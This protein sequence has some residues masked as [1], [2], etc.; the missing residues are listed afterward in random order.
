MQGGTPLKPLMRV[1][2]PQKS[3]YPLSIIRDSTM[4]VITFY[5]ITYYTTILPY[6]SSRTFLGSFWGIMTRDEPYPLRQWAWIHRSVGQDLADIVHGKCNDSFMSLHTS[7]MV[8]KIQTEPP[9]QN[10]VVESFSETQTKWTGAEA[11]PGSAQ[12]EAVT[13]MA[14]EGPLLA[15]IW[16]PVRKGVQL[17]TPTTMVYGI[18]TVAM[19]YKSTYN[20]GHHLVSTTKNY[21]M[22]SSWL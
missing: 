16:C 15:S 20:L 1:I 6:G 9:F 14:S 3:A 13:D 5:Y 18:S 21:D 10:M 17:V 8:F 4:I 2:P 7:W 12:P 19:A 11:L 22:K